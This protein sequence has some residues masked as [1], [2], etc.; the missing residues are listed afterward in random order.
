MLK[1]R[2]KLLVVLDEKPFHLQT[3]FEVFM[4]L[5]HFPGFAAYEQIT[6]EYNFS[7]FLLSAYFYGSQIVRLF[8]SFQLHN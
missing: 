3:E 6:E 7:P 8:Q 5:I 1:I 2:R 4:L